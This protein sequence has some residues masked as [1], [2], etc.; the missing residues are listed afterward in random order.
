MKEYFAID[1]LTVEKIFQNALVVSKL[2]PSWLTHEC[3]SLCKNQRVRVF[4]EKN[5]KLN[6]N[7]G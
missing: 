1:H 2:A 6:Q 5:S 3:K 4:L 7:K